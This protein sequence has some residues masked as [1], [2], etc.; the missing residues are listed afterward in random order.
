VTG[1]PDLANGMKH[2]SWGLGVLIILFGVLPGFFVK[3]RYYKQ[4]ASRQEKIGFWASL[5][6]TLTC[7]PFMLIMPIYLLQVIGSSMVSALGMYLNIYYVCQGDLKQAGIIAGL[8]STVMMTLGI[9]TVP[10][11][12]WI[13]E[14]IGK[15]A[16]LGLTIA[17]G[18]VTN[19][20]IYVCYTPAYPYLQIVPAIFLS[21][22]GSSIWMLIPSM[23]ADIAD[24]D[25][26]ETGERREGSFSSVSS[27]FYKLAITLTAGA[28]GLILAWTGFDVVKYG[29]SQPP[30]VLRRMLNWYVFLPMVCWTGA[31]LLLSRYPLSQ[32]VM[33]DIRSKLEDRR[34]I[35]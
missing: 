16:A 13:S 12:A 18:F 33:K 15:R 24:Y 5:K 2:I 17:F 3:E 28:S 1:E 9:L 14:K 25:E 27:W 11:W 32:S 4:D 23:Q 6:M 21:A 26:L 35:I 20:L 30:E 31:L 8:Q 10:F 22:F 34:G 29:S 19:G 7:R